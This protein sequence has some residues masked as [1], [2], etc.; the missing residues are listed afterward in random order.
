VNWKTH[1]AKERLLTRALSKRRLL[2]ATETR[3][4]RASAG[5][6]RMDGDR[7]VVPVVALVE[8]VIHAVNASCA[9][10]V[11]A[12][13]LVA[14][15]DGWGARP[16]ML[17]HP[18]KNGAMVSANTPGVRDAMQV[19][20][21]LSSRVEGHRLLMDVAIDPAKAESIG[22]GALVA[23]LRAGETLDCS[24]GCFVATEPQAGTFGGKA[25]AAVWK[26]I[27]PDHLAIVT[28]GA[29]DRAMGC[30]LN[31]A[32]Q[33]RPTHTG[34]TMTADELRAYAPPD[35]YAKDAAALRAAAG[36]VAADVEYNPDGPPP[37]PY[38]RDLAELRAAN[39]TPGR[40]VA[41]APGELEM[42]GGYAADVA[43]MRS[44]NR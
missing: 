27:Q 2:A 30:G 34:G 28:R 1:F 40:S 29:C 36:H 31:R 21:I 11:P 43:K 4:F 14:A 32:A 17:G 42:L 16:V 9:E 37:D 41:F 19:G 26:S 39:G 35:P 15:S 18:Q 12:S 10:Y 38:A 5:H 13:V 33:D 25:Y 23:R 7:L 20:T 24:V 3:T 6:A 8:G 44:A 22:A